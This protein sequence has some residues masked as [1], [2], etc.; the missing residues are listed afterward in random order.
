MRIYI[1]L[2]LLFGILASPLKAQWAEVVS[3]SPETNVKS[4]RISTLI[5]DFE[6]VIVSCKEGRKPFVIFDIGYNPRLAELQ[7]S[8]S[9]VMLYAFEGLHAGTVKA[10]KISN[11][12][13]AIFGYEVHSV[14]DDIL[15][16]NF[17]R[18]MMRGNF[19][20]VHFDGKDRE[21]DLKGLTRAIAPHLETCGLTKLIP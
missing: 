4:A 8:D 19:L 16:K 5:N 12:S 13:I 3:V 7:A 10:Y 6:S 21:I 18:R 11:S 14:G 2:I 1:L 15:E 20:H 9:I 17:I